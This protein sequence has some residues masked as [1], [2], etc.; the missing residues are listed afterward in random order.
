M[1]NTNVTEW[2]VPKLLPITMTRGSFEEGDIVQTANATIGVPGIASILFR[3]AQS[4]HKSATYNAPREKYTISPYD[5]ASIPTVYS[6]SSTILNVDTAS[7][8]QKSDANFFGVAQIGMRLVG[9]T[10]GAEAE[11]NDIRLVSDDL[12]SLVG[13]LYIPSDTFLNGTNTLILY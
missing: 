2:C 4:N 9:E 1:E 7:L 5:N 8:N 3:V 13:S 12:G 6:S 10:S 11:I